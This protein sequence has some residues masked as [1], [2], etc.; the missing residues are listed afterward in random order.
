MTP[1]SNLHFADDTDAEPQAS[2]ATHHFSCE[3]CIA[4]F[5]ALSSEGR[6]HSYPGVGCSSADI[7]IIRASIISS[8]TH[9]CGLSSEPVSFPAFFFRYLFLR[10]FLYGRIYLRYAWAH[11]IY[12]TYTKLSQV[13]FLA[14]FHG[15]LAWVNGAFLVLGEGAAIVALLFEAFFVDETLVDVFDAVL[16]NEGHTDLIATSRI[17]DPDEKDPVKQLG[18]PTT[19]AIYSPFSLRQILE[20]IL[21]LPMN[22]VPVAGTPMFLLVTGYRAGPFHH[23]RYFKLLDLT[24]KE[25][26]AFVKQRQLKYTWFGTVALLLQLIPVL[27]ML[28]LLTTAAGSA[29]WVTK[30][31]AKRRALEENSEDDQARA[32]YVDDPV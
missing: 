25:R 27:S 20:F 8:P 16:I 26:Q 11:S 23:W 15:K 19:S 4:S 1:L 24:K 22:L 31:E 10:I 29:L 28:F 18:K 13:A 7:S 3:S 14:I 9:S 30:L 32:R 6:C 5:V 21:F 12:K 2:A 17:L